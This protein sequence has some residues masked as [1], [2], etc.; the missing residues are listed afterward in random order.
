MQM[1]PNILRPKEP[2]TS[3]QAEQT[4]EEIQ[5][6]IKYKKTQTQKD[7]TVLPQAAAMIMKEVFHG[8]QKE[9]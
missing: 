6:S 1:Q 9:S 2:N 8:S 5:I 3:W 7:Q 4:P